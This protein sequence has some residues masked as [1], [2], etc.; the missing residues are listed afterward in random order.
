[1]IE[2]EVTCNDVTDRAEADDPESAIK[3][4][5]CLY[6]E[7]RYANWTFPITTTFRVNGAI[8]AT[9]KGRKP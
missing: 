5:R 4:A 6:E 2:V 9:M 7:H 8:S 3:A 1:M